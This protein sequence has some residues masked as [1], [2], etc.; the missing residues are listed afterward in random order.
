MIAQASIEKLPL[1]DNSIDLIFTD[2]PYVTE[3]IHCY[4]WLANEAM[5]V[6]KPGGFVFAMC[7]GLFL[8]KI[9]R[10]FEDS[11][12]TYF[13]EFQQKSNG[14][15]PTVWKHIN[16]KGYPILA[17]A[18]PMIVYSK[19]LAVPSMGGVHNIF[20]T[21][22]G[23]SEA[24]RFHKWG[25]DVNT[26]RYYIEYFSQVGDIVLDPFIGGGTTLIASELVARRCIGFDI[27]MSAL[28][29][30]RARRNETIIP[31]ALPLFMEHL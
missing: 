17:R 29:T 28:E 30:T 21:G 12:L 23:W 25:Q 2:P 4:E 14:D 31:T 9:Y 5:R 18:K 22:A 15:A 6:L 3:F 24:K 20:E 27:D 13:F 7:G 19:G 1:A 16:G 10:F 26:C 8:P 11:G